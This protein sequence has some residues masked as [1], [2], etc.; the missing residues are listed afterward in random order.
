MEF[1]SSGLSVLLITEAVEHLPQQEGGEY[2]SLCWSVD[3]SPRL[4]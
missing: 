2:L 1:N 3:L 4:E